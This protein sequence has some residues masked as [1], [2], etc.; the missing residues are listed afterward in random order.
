LLE[1]AANMTKPKMLMKS[2]NKIQRT[3][4]RLPRKN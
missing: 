1:K 2:K 3:S 4:I